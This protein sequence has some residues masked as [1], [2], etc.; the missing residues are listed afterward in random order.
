MLVSQALNVINNWKPN[1]VETLA[2]LLP[3]ELIE[4]AYAL[5]DTV[6]NN[7]NNKATHFNLTVF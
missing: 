4:Q 5:T 1:Q 6:K 7:N 2:D 3:L